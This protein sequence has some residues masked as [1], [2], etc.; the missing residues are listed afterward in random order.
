MGAG[1][2]RDYKNLGF[3]FLRSPLLPYDRFFF[4]MDGGSE[5]D[6]SDQ[7][8]TLPSASERRAH[9][10]ARLR[11]VYR[12]PVVREAL[13]VASP[14]AFEALK[15]WESSGTDGAMPD[16]IVHTLIRYY[17]RMCTRSTPFGLL[18]GTTLGRLKRDTDLRLESMEAS[19]RITS[20]DS[21]LIFVVLRGL[22]TEPELRSTIDYYPNESLYRV[23]GGWRY[24]AASFDEATCSVGYE[25]VSLGSDDALAFCLNEARDGVVSSGLVEKLVGSHGAS[26][27]EAR[28]YVDALI[29][30]QVLVSD[31]RVA[32]TGGTPFHEALALLGQAPPTAT[33]RRLFSIHEGLQQLDGARLGLSPAAYAPIVGEISEL[34]V[35]G[36]EPARLLK[37]DMCKTASAASL[38]RNVVAAVRATIARLHDIVPARTDDELASM[39]DAFVQRFGHNAVPLNVAL[40]PDVGIAS[41]PSS[42]TDPLTEGLGASSGSADSSTGLRWAARDNYLLRKLHVAWQKAADEIT[43]DERDLRNLQ[44]SNQPPLPDSVAA[45]FR[46]AGNRR[47]DHEV[48]FTAAAA[49]AAR[50]LGRFGHLE[51]QMADVLRAIAAHEAAADP[52]AVLAEVVHLPQGRMANIASRPSLREYEIPY[53]GKSSV[54]RAH[55][56]RTDDLW[57]TVRGSRFMLWSKVLR[58]RVEPRLSCAHDAMTNTVPVYRFLTLLQSQGTC[59]WLAW[60]W[61][62]LQ[63]APFLPRVRIGSV[64]VARQTWTIEGDELQAFQSEASDEGLRATTALR[65]RLRMPRWVAL[66]DSDREL[67]VDLENAFSLEA[68]MPLIRSRSRVRFVEQWPARHGAGIQGPEGA[69]AGE[70]LV[71]FVRTNPHAR[72]SYPPPDFCEAFERWSSRLIS[73]N[74]QTSAAATDMILAKV[75]DLI[76]SEAASSDLEAWFFTNDAADEPTIQ[77]VVSCEGSLEASEKLRWLEAL[78]PF[79]GDGRLKRWSIEPHI[80][81]VE[82][83]GGRAALRDIHAIQHYDSTAALAVLRHEVD[84]EQRWQCALMSA[85]RLLHDFGLDAAAR[86]ELVRNL[87]QQ[88]LRALPGSENAERHL[89]QRYRLYRG[90]VEALVALAADRSEELA[91]IHAVF[92]QRSDRLRPAIQHL[93]SLQDEARLTRDGHE[94]VGRLVRGAI[95]RRLRESVQAYELLIVDFLHRAYRS[96]RG[97]AAARSNEQ[98]R[99]YDRR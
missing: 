35:L 13:Y 34:D 66:A 50:L 84:G 59:P 97:R 28:A 14:H 80:P 86:V 20:V 65:A 9:F 5:A 81:D 83:W 17:A 37:V 11:R 99:N 43:L 69:Y 53:L 2:I 39:R 33:A 54:D 36:L 61:G 92:D 67:P 58:R 7:R 57:L 75:A 21:A 73:L 30:N 88:C 87:R 76:D 95:R 82:R 29:E 8:S 71:P 49:P 98:G 46:V 4:L 56:I 22:E 90:H 44:V 40:D 26:E 93:R 31:F 12:D 41:T 64:I 23:D 42:N 47:G 60:Q 38:G 19:R 27:D 78:A 15:R 62:R 51:P 68:L 3:F 10:L 89:S 85:D 63:H 45:W 52:D 79:E 25:L 77:V 74:L 24:V 18:A 70:I 48:Y 96:Q 91:H 6:A 72:R 32:V 55:Q 94:I 16:D 1:A